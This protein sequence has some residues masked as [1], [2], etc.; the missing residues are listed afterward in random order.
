MTDESKGLHVFIGKLSADIDALELGNLPGAASSSPDQILMEICVPEL[1]CRSCAI[2]ATDVSFAGSGSRILEAD[3]QHHA[4]LK[5]DSRPKT[6]EIT[7]WHEQNTKC[8]LMTDVSTNSLINGGWTDLQL[9]DGDNNVGTL[10]IH[11]TTSSKPPVTRLESELSR[12]ESITS[13]QSNN[14]RGLTPLPMSRTLSRQSDVRRAVP[15]P[16]MS[17]LSEA[18]SDVTSYQNNR[19]PL[20]K[21][22]VEPLTS[23]RSDQ[24]FEPNMYDLTNFSMLPSNMLPGQPYRPPYGPYSGQSYYHPSLNQYPTYSSNR[25]YSKSPSSMSFLNAPYNSRVTGYRQDRLQP[26]MLTSA[27]GDSYREYVH[28]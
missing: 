8:K 3:F 18:T 12:A 21:F 28:I 14:T 7:L 13:F 26:V 24:K 17:R 27:S 23:Q 20:P 16:S 2:G 9:R 10:R 19:I 25:A 6:L 22:D 15:P 11:T 5:T 1:K 4:F